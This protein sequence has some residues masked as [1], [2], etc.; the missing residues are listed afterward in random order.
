MEDIFFWLSLVAGL[1]LY[2]QTTKLDYYMK[3][4]QTLMQNRESSLKAYDD[5]I[6]VVRAYQYTV[7]Q[8]VTPELRAKI[9]EEMARL[10]KESEVR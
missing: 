4:C 6:N 7:N 1:L 10:R 5:Y 8:V 2:Y 9:D 3:L